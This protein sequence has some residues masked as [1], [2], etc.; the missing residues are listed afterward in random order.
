MKNLMALMEFEKIQNF[1]QE[2]CGIEFDDQKSGLLERKLNWIIKNTPNTTLEELYFKICLRKDTELIQSLIE[3]IAVNETFWFRDA[4]PWLILEKILI[5][6]YINEFRAKKRYRVRIWS[7]ACSYGQE[8]Y[9]IAMC[10]D[11]YLKKHDITDIRLSDFE[12]VATDISKNA[13]EIA[14]QGKYDS[15]S[16]SRGID[17]SYKQK[18]FVCE[19]RSWKISDEIIRAIDFRHFNLISDSMNYDEFDLVYCRNVMIY[20]SEK[21]KREIYNKIYKS[22]KTKGTLFIGSAE[23]LDDYSQFFSM[24]QNEIGVYFTKKEQMKNEFF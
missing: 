18:Y 2:T 19:D 4:A 21:N 9:S 20:F 12:I 24:E 11:N 17:E 3:N 23:I 22:M 1:I 15:I 13:L 8:P 16:M 10:I 5:P 7:A 14:R 6:E